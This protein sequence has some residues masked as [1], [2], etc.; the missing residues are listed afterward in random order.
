M[1]GFAVIVAEA[2]LN[3]YNRFHCQN[4]GIY[5]AEKVG[6]TIYQQNAPL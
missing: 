2:G 4:F 1:A 6:K 5:G 3:V